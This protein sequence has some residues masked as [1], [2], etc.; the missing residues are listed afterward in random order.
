MEQNNSFTQAHLDNQLWLNELR[1]YS[2]ETAIFQ[3]HLEEL[4]SRNTSLQESDE[5]GYFQ[6]QFARMSDQVTNMLNE[7]QSAEAKMAMYAKS[8]RT[9]DL[10]NIIVAD[11][12]Q[13][14][15]SINN[16]KK[17]YETFKEKFKKF[18]SDLY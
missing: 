10:E 15:D 5:A 6:N 2:D 4:I 3:K 8:D 13:F 18:E 12:Y 9:A 17:E 14:R 1:F 7:L 16:F 11:H